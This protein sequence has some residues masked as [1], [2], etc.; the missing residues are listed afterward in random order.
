[1]SEIDEIDI[2]PLDFL[3]AVYLNPNLPLNTRMRAAIEA[4]PYRHSKLS[5]NTNVHYE[6]KDFAA[7]LERAIERSRQ[8]VPL[9]NGPTPELPAEELK[10]PFVRP[11]YRRY[12]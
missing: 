10:Q 3:E 5:V 8:P 4:A 7:Q 2:T 1:M 12:R 11:N 6:G 9:L